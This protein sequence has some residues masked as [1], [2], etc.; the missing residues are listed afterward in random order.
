MA[1]KITKTKEEA[2]SQLNELI[3]VFKKD[4][5]SFISS[6]YNEAQL[7]TDFLN[8]LL[9]SFGWDVNNESGQTQ[10]L[11]EVIQEESIEVEDSSTKK[12]PDY[13]LRVQGQRKLFV[14]A[15]K[16]AVDVE[17]SNKSAFQIRRY[18]WNATLGISILTNFDKF[19]VY[20]CRHKPNAEDDARVARLRIFDYT[21]YITS[22]DELYDLISFKS[23]SSGRLDELFSVY[24]KVGQTF[25]SYFLDQIENWRAKLAQSAIAR[26][27]KLDS[28]DI[29]FLIQRLLN[30]IVFL[31]ICEDRKIEKY[32]TLKNIKSYD[33]LKSLFIQS[34]KKYNSGLFDFIEDSLSLEIDLD[35]QILIEIFNELYYPLSPYDFSVVDPAILSQIY[36]KFLGSRVIIENGR[37]SSVLREPEVAA[38]NGVVP[39]PKLI[40][41]KI[42]KETLSP[43]CD[44]KSAK[45]LAE[46]RMAD[47]CCGSGTFLISAYDFLLQ[48]IIKRLTEENVSDSQLIYKLA[49]GT[50]V[51]PLKAKRDL[52]VQNFYGV[53][54]NPYAVEVTKFSLLL[55]ILEGESAESIDYFLNRYS[56]KV[57]PSL[58]EN[59][60]CGNSLVD[61]KFFNLYPKA[62]DDRELLLKVKPFSWHKEFPFLDE[63]HGFDAIIGN[64]PYVRIQKLVKYSPE[65]IKYYQSGVSGFAVAKKETIDKYYVF[66]QR[67]IA[68]LNPKGFLGYIIPNKFFIVKGGK[69][70]RK[71]IIENSSLSKII[72]FGVTQVFPARSTYTAI[73][74]LQKEERGQFDFKRVK[75]INS[76]LLASEIAVGLKTSADKIYIFTPEKE[77]EK[78]FIFSSNGAEL[79]VEKDICLPCIY[80]LSFGNFDTIAPN[81][82]IIFPYVIKDGH[83][84]V[85]YE[86]RL[87]RYEH[88]WNYLNK[89][90]KQLK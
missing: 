61:E 49:D 74:I 68:L 3:V 48:V 15:K 30:R 9:M 85:I 80:N 35:K 7:R 55:K 27:E 17:A 8:P 2:L 63:N 54:I 72:H 89:H 40:V 67:A 82:Q 26:N 70:L 84:Q 43:L 36:E 33:E 16:P 23:A 56:G 81:S 39:T 45:Q 13:T 79:E 87:K 58:S 53:D 76:E 18:G 21:E 25:D 69:A 86:S 37:K 52:L 38:S 57:L 77:T 29:N 51:L 32:E 73:L 34:D 47:I 50:S 28:D 1:Y 66:I 71:Y 42:V 4:R 41:E 64:P 62:I 65:E 11:R 78:T 10:F 31:R 12:N 22:Y 83:A 60:K 88:C 24:E 19:I 5:K 75:R 6:K 20:D 90:K 46:I 44:G 14:E 59:I